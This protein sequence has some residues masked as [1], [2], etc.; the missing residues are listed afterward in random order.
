MRADNSALPMRRIAAAT[1]MVPLGC[2]RSCDLTCERRLKRSS[3]RAA[4]DD[5]R[6]QFAGSRDRSSVRRGLVGPAM[7]VAER[8][9]VDPRLERLLVAPAGHHE[10][11]VAIVGR[12]Q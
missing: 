11:D 8:R 2:L 3:L 12:L 5:V 9:A 7:A 4:S 10:P 6:P 1:R